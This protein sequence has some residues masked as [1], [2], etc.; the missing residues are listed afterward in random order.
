MERVIRSAEGRALAVSESGDLDGYPV[1]VHM[2]T[3]NSRRLYGRNVTDAAERGLRLISYDRPGY[4]GSDADPGR[5][6]VDCVAD[7]R[8]ICAALGIER[9]AMWGISGGG[10]HVLACA[11]LLP[12]LAAAVASLA[13]PAPYG[14][15]GLDWFDGMGQDNV[16][17]TRLMLADEK[18]ARVKMDQD[19]EAFLAASP[20]E[21]AEGMKSLLSPVDE[22]VLTGELGEFMVYSMREGLAPGSQG[23]WDDSLATARPW[24]FDLAQI[25]VPVL[26]LHG[27]HDQF[28]PFAH[29]QWLAAHVPGA[30]AWLFDD[31]GHLSLMEHRVGDVH[32]WLASHR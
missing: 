9:L 17:D 31:E 15:E 23:W 1:L 14:A 2:G 24:G 6:V 28:V 20:E 8:A 12:D 22:A 10:P 4:G 25:S 29:G 18:A 3:P 13:S 21:L 7:V 32:A 11:A 5:T 30:E 16:D 26:L 27:R 19:R